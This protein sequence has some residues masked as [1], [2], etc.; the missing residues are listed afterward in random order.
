MSCTGRK[1]LPEYLRGKY[2]RY[3]IDELEDIRKKISDA[4]A[5][6]DYW[7]RPF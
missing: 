2:S 3:K 4:D 7:K 5:L 1:K 6:K